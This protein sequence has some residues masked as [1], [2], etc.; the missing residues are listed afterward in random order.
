A[1]EN[2][3]TDLT[4]RSLVGHSERGVAM[5]A[6][7]EELWVEST[8]A[9]AT[10]RAVSLERVRDLRAPRDELRSPPV[11]AVRQV[12]PGPQRPR[13]AR[14]HRLRPARRGE[15]GEYPHRRGGALGERGGCCSRHRDCRQDPAAVRG[16]T[17]SMVLTLNPG[18]FFV[19]SAYPPPHLDLVE[20]GSEGDV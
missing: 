17:Q 14:S 6:S 12:L 18:T 10:G 13:P 15:T 1:L 5:V 20:I 11:R 16:S 7:P 4:T 2:L 8:I 19:A 3:A 9:R